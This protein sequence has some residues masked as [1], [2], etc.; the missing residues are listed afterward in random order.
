MVAV[1]MGRITLDNLR[2]IANLFVVYGRVHHRVNVHSFT[3]RLSTYELHESSE[4]LLRP[5]ST[6]YAFWEHSFNTG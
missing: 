2:H 3:T 1:D 6:N 4:E 5:S